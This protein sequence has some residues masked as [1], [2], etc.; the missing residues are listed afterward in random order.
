MFDIGQHVGEMHGHSPSTP[1]GPLDG[2]KADIP[3]EISKNV[4]FAMAAEL[5][6]ESDRTRIDITSNKQAFVV[7]QVDMVKPAVQVIYSYDHCYYLTVL[8]R[9]Y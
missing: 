8:K 9:Q 6:A 2:W 3:F 7:S 4:A 5:S 1:L